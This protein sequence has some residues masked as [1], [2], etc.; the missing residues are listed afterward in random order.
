MLAVITA[1]LTVLIGI[2]AVAATVAAASV[3]AC[4]DYTYKKNKNN[5]SIY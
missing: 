1:G 2:H 5:D 3:L 4:Q